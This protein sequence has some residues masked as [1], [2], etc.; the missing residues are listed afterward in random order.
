MRRAYSHT[1]GLA[2]ELNLTP[3]CPSGRMDLSRSRVARGSKHPNARRERVP[4]GRRVA[5]MLDL[6]HVASA[7]GML[8]YPGFGSGAQSCA[9]LSSCQELGSRARTATVRSELTSGSKVDFPDMS[10]AGLHKVAPSYVE[11]TMYHGSEYIPSYVDRVSSSQVSA[12]E[13]PSMKASWTAD[14]GLHYRA[15]RSYMLGSTPAI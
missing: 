2:Q 3:C 9:V 8:T 7:T 1:L 6:D 12:A 15:L 10:N 4:H 11:N 5:L 14:T 13:T